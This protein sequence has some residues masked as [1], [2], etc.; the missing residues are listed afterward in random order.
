MSMKRLISHNFWLKLF[1]LMLAGMI[2]YAVFS[3]QDKPQNVPGF[4]TGVQTRTFDQ[5]AVH[6]LKSPSDTR[7][8]KI[9]PAAV[10]VT[11]TADAQT[12]ESLTP[13]DL[14]VFI[15]LTSM[16]FETRKHDV[17]IKITKP[18]NEFEVSPSYVFIDRL[19]P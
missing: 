3:I 16:H 7:L 18:V 4:Q 13:H 14:Q 19:S 10:N 15:N 6:I 5:V 11:V 17:H 1:S 9:S 12:L 8:Y 2:W